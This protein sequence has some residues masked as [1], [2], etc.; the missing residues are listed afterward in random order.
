[1]GMMGAGALP[2]GLRLG[3]PRG[4]PS[5]G[6]PSGL[7][8]GLPPRGMP[9]RGAS[10]IA[11]SSRA[12]VLAGAKF[13]TLH[14]TVVSG[15][16]LHPISGP[17]SSNMDSLVVVRVGV[18]EHQTPICTGGGTRPKYNATLQFDIRA[19]R[20]VDFSVFYRRG[21][22]ATGFD[23]VCVGRGRANFM[24]WIAQGNFMGD[25][26]IKDDAGQTAGSLQ[27]STKFD[28][29]PPS[30]ATPGTALAAPTSAIKPV[31]INSSVGP[32]D[33]SG[34]FT[35][36]EVRDAFT[37]LDLDQN[38][39]VGAAELTH[40][41]VNIGENVTDEEVDEMIRM[42]DTDGDGQVSYSEFYFMVQGKALPKEG[43]EAVEAAKPLAS[44]P[45]AA[46]RN[47]RKVALQN[48]MAEYRWTPECKFCAQN[49]SLLPCNAPSS[50]NHTHFHYSPTLFLST[51]PK[52]HQC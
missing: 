29:A 11:A 36:K 8:P 27:V 9:P 13:G 51:P 41:L 24:P 14:L 12:T 50:R 3:F 37:S 22:S 21:A 32:R 17:S 1:M 6:P 18:T 26:Q 43:R 45:A 16:D 38:D 7:P 39:Y 20:E 25:I 40:V 33:P 31:E 35:D 34:K 44:A 10:S 30:V 52:P 5:G 23:D 2:P 4:M 47:A 46:Q 42:C 49:E 19:E 48:F 15:S 28:R